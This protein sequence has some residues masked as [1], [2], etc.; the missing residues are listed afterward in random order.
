MLIGKTYDARRMDGPLWSMNEKKKREINLRPVLA[1]LQRREDTSAASSSNL[2]SVR[3]EHEHFTRKPKNDQALTRRQSHTLYSSINAH[4][5]PTPLAIPD[6]PLE[7]RLN[8]LYPPR[9]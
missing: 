5:A 4:E 7:S 2:S 9:G 8:A 6:T 3:L 1:L